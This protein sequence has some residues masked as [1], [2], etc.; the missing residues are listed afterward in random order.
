VQCPA[1]AAVWLAPWRGC[2]SSI[3]QARHRL[4]GVPALLAEQKEPLLAL[5]VR[6]S[7]P[8]VTVHMQLHGDDEHAR[9]PAGS[10]S[11]ARAV[12]LAHADAA[13]S[14]I[15]PDAEAATTTT[16]LLPKRQRSCLHPASIRKPAARIR[17]LVAAEEELSTDR[18]LGVV[19]FGRP[20]REAALAR[21]SCPRS[22][23]SSNADAAGERRGG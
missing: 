2:C 22:A 19:D 7:K 12:A 21:V 23:R 9:D 13:L 4:R 20:F 18:P 8:D 5:G 10:P 3:P 1:G 17:L 16:V 11:P 14:E 6:S 15:A